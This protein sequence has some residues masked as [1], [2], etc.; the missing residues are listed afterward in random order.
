MACEISAREANQKFS[1][2]L[3]RAARGQSVVIT[4]RG[5][6]VA[7]LIRYGGAAENE[8]QAWSRLLSILET[9]LPLGGSRIDRDKLHER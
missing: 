5:K 7:K 9:G 1:D 8:G 3:G 6:P 4:R 2:L